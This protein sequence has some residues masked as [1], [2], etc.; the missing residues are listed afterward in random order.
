MDTTTPTAPTVTAVKRI[1]D[2]VAWAARLIGESVN[3][4]APMVHNHTLWVGKSLALVCDTRVEHR[5]YV[6]YCGTT[7]CGLAWDVRLIN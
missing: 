5:H 6:Q 3:S 2:S 4:G 7:S 1:R